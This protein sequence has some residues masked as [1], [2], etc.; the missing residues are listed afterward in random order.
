MKKKKMAKNKQEKSKQK[1][2]RLFCETSYEEVRVVRV[3]WLRYLHWKCKRFV[4]L[5]GECSWERPRLLFSRHGSP[6]GRGGGKI[7]LA[8]NQ[9]TLLKRP[10]TLSQSGGSTVHF[11]ERFSFRA[12]WITEANVS[13]WALKQRDKGHTHLHVPIVEDK[14][15]TCYPFVFQSV[16]KSKKPRRV[17][18]FVLALRP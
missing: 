10:Y 5:K 6:L 16:P 7:H 14:L 8:I 1:D 17:F 11:R 12:K 2:G 3:S 4:Q 18:F 9:H 13:I 15:W